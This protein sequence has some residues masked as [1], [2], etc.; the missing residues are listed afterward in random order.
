MKETLIAFFLLSMFFFSGCAKQPLGVNMEVTA[1]CGC[2]RCCGW[3][4]GSWQYLKLDFWK[5]YVSSGPGKGKPYSGLTASGNKPR[6]PRPGLFSA[7]SL[8][9]PWMIPVR[10]AFFPWLLLPKDGT[11]AADTRY[12]P[13]GTRMYITGYGYGCV[14]DRGS[15]IKGQQRLDVFYNSHQKAL[16]WGRQHVYVRVLK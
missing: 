8:K 12:Y 7:D 4:R 16:D 2:S 1:Y 9:R 5:R 6:E 10:I 15:A 11:L 14:E 3:E 13:F